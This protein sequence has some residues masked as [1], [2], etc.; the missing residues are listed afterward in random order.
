M[1]FEQESRDPQKSASR[2]QSASFF[3]RAVDTARDF[4]KDASEAFSTETQVDENFKRTLEYIVDEVEEVQTALGECQAAFGEARLKVGGQ[5]MPQNLAQIGAELARVRAW[6]AA[7]K[8]IA[9]EET[10][11]Q[12]EA[13]W[14][15]LHN[16]N[17]RL[18]ANPSGPGFITDLHQ[19]LGGVVT[20]LSSVETQGV[21]AG[22]AA[23]H[24]WVQKA[25]AELPG[26][27]SVEALVEHHALL[28]AA[29]EPARKKML[30]GADMLK[31]EFEG[32]KI[33][34]TEA[35]ADALDK[36]RL[37]DL[38]HLNEA[39]GL[40]RKAALGLKMVS[41]FERV[42][43]LGDLLLAFK[44]VQGADPRADTM[45]AARAWEALFKAAGEVGGDWFPPPIA[46]YMGIVV[47]LSEAGIITRTVGNLTR[48]PRELD[49]QK[50]ANDKSNQVA[51]R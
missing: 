2:A 29:I 10:I 45:G 19:A 32:Q 35:A 11:R 18:S 50:E 6:F 31:A 7:L 21:G 30:D 28:G 4:A 14:K 37:K 51:P 1:G 49:A 47:Q 46:Q 44:A 27:F 15:S 43:H 41:A 34:A 42:D 13:C 5:L 38:K 36:T 23:H 3:G 9:S 17:G 48:R 39:S 8:P 26:D 22:L 33:A 24:Q 12:H 40:L 16:S 20:G 25:H